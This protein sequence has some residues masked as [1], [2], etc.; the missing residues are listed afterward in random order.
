MMP[1]KA[2]SGLLTV[3]ADWMN[4]H[5]G[6]AEVLKAAEG[7]ARCGDKKIRLPGR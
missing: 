6:G 7:A 2:G 5:F 3:F 4:Y 1:R